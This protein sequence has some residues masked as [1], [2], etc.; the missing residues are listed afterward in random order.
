[1]K[2]LYE[3]DQLIHWSRDV[4]PGLALR[5]CEIPWSLDCVDPAPVRRTL[6]KELAPADYVGLLW[7]STVFVTPD[8]L[9]C[10][11]TAKHQLSSLEPPVSAG[12][13]TTSLRSFCVTSEF[14]VPATESGAPNHP[15]NRRVWRETVSTISPRLGST[16][17]HS[18]ALQ[19]TTN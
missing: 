18:R 6:F 15:E 19:S 14:C 16:P 3:A 12:G 10:V 1:M 9:S 7:I 4:R 17:E 13:T 2:G 8:G 11:F 5:T